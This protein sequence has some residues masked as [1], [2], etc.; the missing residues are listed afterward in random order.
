[1]VARSYAGDG[2]LWKSSNSLSACATLSHAVKKALKL[3]HRDIR[4]KGTQTSLIEQFLYPKFGPRQMWEEVAAR[5]TIMGGRI[6]TGYSADRVITDGWQVRAVEAVNARTGERETFQGDHF[7][8]T[9]PVNEIMRS[10]DPL[11]PENVLEVSDGLVYRD[12]ITVGLL[13]PSL[14]INEDTPRR[15][16]LISDNWIYIQEPDVLL[17][18]LQIF[19]NWSPFMVADPEKVWL[20]WNTSVIR[21]TT[22]GTAPIRRSSVLAT[23]RT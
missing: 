8:S 3:E 2:P 6:C 9:A 12:F 11:P 16:K 21:R 13:V 1:M 7:F 15:K 4:Q 14:L 22:F 17:G 10:L 20:A 23:Q 5:V 19:N 18:R